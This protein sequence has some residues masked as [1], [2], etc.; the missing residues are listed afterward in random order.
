MKKFKMPWIS[1]IKEL[2]KKSIDFRMWTF[3][4]QGLLV[5]GISSVGLQ[6]YAYHSEWNGD[7]HA[8]ARVVVAGVDTT[9]PEQLLVGIEIT[10]K[11]GW[12]TYWRFPGEGG[13][14][15]QF[16]L[17][18]SKQQQTIK[19][20]WPAPQR[21]VT[22]YDQQ[23][24]V[25]YG[26]EDH[27][28][29][30]LV[31]TA[32]HAHQPS[33]LLLK[34]DYA[35]C[36]EL[37]IP[38]SAVFTIDL[39][40][41]Y[42]DLGALKEYQLALKQVPQAPSDDSINVGQPAIETLPD[43]SYMLAVNATSQG[44]VHP[45]VILE[46]ADPMVMM[47]VPAL[48]LYHGGRELKALIKLTPIDKDKK[49]VLNPLTITVIDRD[50]RVE[51]LT[52]AD[53]V[54]T[55]TDVASY[56]FI[57]LCALLGGLILNIMPCVLPV[58]SLKLLGVIRSRDMEVSKIR[59]GFLASG[60]GIV[61]SFLILAMATITF[62]HLG[63][64][65]GWGFHFQEPRFLIALVIVI[66]LFSLSL[67]GGFT[68][69]I[70]MWL[71]RFVTG[72]ARMEK[73]LVEHFFTGMIA[74]VLATPCTAPFLGT[75]VSFAL[76]RNSIDILV[77]F[78]VMGLGLALPFFAVSL[79]PKVVH[80]LPKPGPWMEWVKKLFGALLFGT[81]LWLMWILSG[82]IG[83]PAVSV[84][85]LLSIILKFV[86]QP[87]LNFLKHRW[88]KMGSLLVIICLMFILPFHMFKRQQEQQHKI[89]RLWS[90]FE[91][92]MIAPAVAK[93]KVVVVDITADWCVNCK[94]NE[95]FVLNRSDVMAKLNTPNIVL[96]KGDLTNKSE[97][98]DAFLHKHNAYGIPFMVVYGPN[99][100]HGIE[101]AGI[102]NRDR[103][104]KAIQRAS[105]PVL[106]NN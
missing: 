7:E 94:V 95:L 81:A 23:R 33:Q 13:I 62:R 64:A 56:G 84:L 34:A 92:S 58:L 28:F 10:L 43:H 26:Y 32:P 83:T 25:T 53:F 102:L 40:A 67:L 60:C 38:A 47:E 27:V 46:I 45:D 80:G 77:I 4:F 91:E 50:H 61:F 11:K 59:L 14:A 75:A 48:S 18:D 36:S 8:Q 3:L 41:D 87:K 16:T 72:P 31:I 54:T 74:T 12:H 96:M 44:F 101:M 55:S 86:V 22:F 82:Q 52:R 65:V 71:E 100:T 73:H 20:L 37:C 79:F 76:S 9:H 97:I 42:H 70:P 93:G 19:V 104:F 89:D 88:V 24:S 69:H 2:F 21:F 68:I 90:P 63:M 1:T 78:L 15:P 29:F 66:M 105:G 57:L 85:L 99:A 39:P 49:P 103:L 35:V 106:K 30:P 6:A 98:I 5:M 51:K 17:Q